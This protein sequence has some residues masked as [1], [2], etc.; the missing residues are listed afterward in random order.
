MT[1]G[2]VTF[3]IIEGEV[4]SIEVQGNRWFRA[5]YLQ[6]RL[7]LGAGPPLNVNALQEQIQL[8]L[9]D[10]RIRRLTAE[11]KPGLKPGEAVL[12]VLVE[13]R[14]PYRLWS[15][16]N[17]YQS[18]SVGAEIWIGNLEHQNLTGNGDILTLR[19]GR[20]EGVDGLLDFKYSLPFTARD[21]TL[22]L[23]YR[24]DP[25]DVTEQPFAG[26][27][28]ESKEDIYTVTLRQPVYRTLNS[29]FALELTGERI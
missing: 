18:P 9:E 4:T 10:P 3:Q 1:E 12:N 21:T 5:S 28:I 19:Y 7:L 6:K 11:V 13:E 15:D 20:S 29:E 17:N 22:I 16:F 8:L 25:S 24:K 14:G 23:Q 2:V 27:D 26:L